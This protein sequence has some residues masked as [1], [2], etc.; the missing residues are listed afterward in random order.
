VNANWF[1]T[2][3]AV[4]ALLHSPPWFANSMHFVTWCNLVETCGQ[5][6]LK[7]KESQH[8]ISFYEK[9]VQQTVNRTKYLG[10][11]FTKAL[12]SLT[13]CIKLL[14]DFGWKLIVSE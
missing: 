13:Q 9:I 14:N 5:Y 2:K 7:Y 3:E 4:T 12:S 1:L 11:H 8:R 10:Y 6:E